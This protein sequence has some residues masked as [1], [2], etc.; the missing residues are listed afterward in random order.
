MSRLAMIN[1][2][3][4]FLKT[5]RPYRDDNGHKVKVLFLKDYVL[6]A[7]LRE[8]KDFTKC[9]TD[10]YQAIEIALEWLKLVVKSRQQLELS[11]LT[12]WDLKALKYKLGV[13]FTLEDLVQ[14][15]HAIKNQ[16]DTLNVK[17]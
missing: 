1:T 7:L 13:D 14:L 2:M 17:K 3:K 10:R 4:R 9:A 16:I 12:D 6:Y 11:N 8:K 5:E 15:E